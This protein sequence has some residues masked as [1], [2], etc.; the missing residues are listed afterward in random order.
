[1]GY[2]RKV[3]E[4]RIMCG[5]PHFQADKSLRARQENSDIFQQLHHQ[6][7]RNSPFLPKTNL[8][9][10]AI[11]KSS[12]NC[13]FTHSRSTS[14]NELPTKGVDVVSERFETRPGL[15]RLLLLLL[16]RI[17]VVLNDPPSQF[18]EKPKS[19]LER[20]IEWLSVVRI[21]RLPTDQTVASV[22][23]DQPQTQLPGHALDHS[24]VALHRPV[25]SRILLLVLVD[26]N[27]RTHLHTHSQITHCC[28]AIH[29][30]RRNSKV[31]ERFRRTN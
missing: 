9:I 22:P 11:L 4:A 12:I 25:E 20:E 7:L 24:L 31:K 29:L 23:C 19:H 18:L 26:H 3:D 14:P 8:S 5:N 6:I 30:K 28:P 16:L 10:N 15:T 21:G 2:G 1:M 27:D 17:G 13:Q